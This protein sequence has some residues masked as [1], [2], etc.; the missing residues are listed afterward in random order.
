MRHLPP[1][2]VPYWDFEAPGIPDAEKD[3]SA[4][5][6]AASGLLELSALAP[7]KGAY[8]RS[9]AEHMLR[10]LASSAYLAE[11]TPSCGILNHCVA[12]RSHGV[13][14]DVSLIYADYYFVE[15]LLR[16]RALNPH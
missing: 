8:Y 9:A 5:A 13:E 16:H 2:G 10:S 6:I 11:G 1:D 3:A 12:D 4:A 14:V 15:A 7:E